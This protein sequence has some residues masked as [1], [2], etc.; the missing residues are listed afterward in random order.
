MKEKAMQLLKEK[1][2]SELKLLLN[3]ISPMDVASMLNGLSNEDLILTFRL[4][5]KDL[6][7][8][9]FVEMDSDNQELLIS[10]FN[11][12][13][14]KAI[15]DE[16]YL[17]D[18]VDIIE[19]MPANVVNRILK[20]TDPATRNMINEVLKYPKDSAGSI[21]N[22]E[23]VSLRKAMLLIKIVNYLE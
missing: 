18:V 15:V 5:S 2:F 23:Y 13:E 20:Y 16:L 6:A 17:D 12:K 21:M 19:E 9:T 7:A 10:A 3:D 1:R 11:D 14:L 22:V 8:E 4:L